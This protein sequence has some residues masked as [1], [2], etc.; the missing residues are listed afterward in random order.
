[1]SLDKKKK[2]ITEGIGLLGLYMA[3]KLQ[4]NRYTSDPAEAIN[5]YLPCNPSTSSE[6]RGD[7]V[8]EGGGSRG[9]TWRV[10]GIRRTAGVRD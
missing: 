9:R 1:M 5:F 10:G 8:V 7:E 3:M 4:I 6:H 2:E